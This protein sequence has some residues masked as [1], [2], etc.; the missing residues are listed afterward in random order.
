MLPAFEQGVDGIDRE[1]QRSQQEI[2]AVIMVKVP[3]EIAAIVDLIREEQYREQE[4][5][6]RADQHEQ[7]Q[8]EGSLLLSLPAEQD[9]PVERQI[10]E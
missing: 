3:L 5:D 6:R 10:Q 1:K 4:T 7:E 2:R 9:P 8:E